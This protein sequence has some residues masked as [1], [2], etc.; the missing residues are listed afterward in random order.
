MAPH[1]P[2]GTR[3]SGKA[4][5]VWGGH[6]IRTPQSPSEGQHDSS[7]QLRPFSSTAVTAVCWAPWS[8]RGCVLHVHCRA[9]IRASAAAPTRTPS[10]HATVSTCQC[11]FPGLLTAPSVPCFLLLLKIKDMTLLGVT[12]EPHDRMSGSPSTQPCSPS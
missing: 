1:R 5:G 11:A 12:G 8:R 6:C 3:G 2:A 9:L 7:H 4:A 10:P